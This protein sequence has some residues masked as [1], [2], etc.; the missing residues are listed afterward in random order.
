[1]SITEHRYPLLFQFIAD[2]QLSIRRLFIGTGYYRFLD[3]RVNPVLFVRSLSADFLKGRFSP[4]F[5]KSLE[6]VEAVSGIPHDFTSLRYVPQLFCRFENPGFY[7]DDLL[8]VCHSLLLV[9]G[10]IIF[11]N[12]CQILSWLLQIKGNQGYRRFLL[13]GNAK[14]AVEWG[15]L[16]FGYN[17]KQ[18]YRVTG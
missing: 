16:S 12:K 11:R 14:V 6:P 4:G 5:I 17:L 3:I 15:L 2:P 1:M 9:D 7:F 18:L 8:L 10:Y 13:W